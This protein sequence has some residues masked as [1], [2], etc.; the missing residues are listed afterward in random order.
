MNPNPRLRPDSRSQQ[1][2]TST[3]RNG[4]K[5]SNNS[6]FVV[7]KAKFPTQTRGPVFMS[8]V[9]I[10]VGAHV[11]QDV[12]GIFMPLRRLWVCRLHRAP[13]N[14][15]ED[16]FSRRRELATHTSRLEKL[17]AVAADAKKRICHDDSFSF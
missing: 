11:A 12:A 1:I 8:R 9:R 16:G 2:R 17:R 14:G 5:R 6:C 3:Q 13:D 4:A 7:V 10:V 15:E